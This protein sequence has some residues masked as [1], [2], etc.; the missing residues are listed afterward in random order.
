MPFASLRPLARRPGKSSP[1][2]AVP[3]VEAL[4]GRSLPSATTVTQ[5]TPAGGP[6]DS[7][8]GVALSSVASGKVIETTAGQPFSGVVA[9]FS[10]PGPLAATTDTATINW[11]DGQTSAGTI[12]PQGNGL[13]AVS[14][15]HSYA[16]APASY[17]VVVSLGLTGGGKAFATSTVLVYSFPSGPPINASE[18]QKFSGVVA[19]FTAPNATAAS[20]YTATI[21]W[22]DG[23]TSAGTV[24]ALGNGHF[25]VS[26]SN[27]YAD[28]GTYGVSVRI[29]QG[30]AASWT[31]TTSA[32]VADA[33]FWAT[34]TFQHVGQGQ[35]VT[36]GLGTLTDLNPLATPDDFTVTIDWGDG[37]KTPGTL[38]PTGKGA[39]N[40]AG[41]H[42]YNSA[43]ARTLTVTVTGEGGRVATANPLITVDAPRAPALSATGQPIATKEGQGFNG[44]VATF[45]DPS[46]AAAG[47]YAAAVSWGNGQTSAGTVAALGGG[48][49][50]VSGSNT[51]R[52]AG[53]YAVGV[54]VSRPGGVTAAAA[55]TAVVADEPFWASRTFQR[56]GQGQPVTGVLGTLVDLNPLA[57]AGDFTVTID[58]ADGTK[59]PGLLLPKGNGTFDITGSHDYTSAGARTLDV[60]VTD[61]GGRT[62]TTNPLISVNAW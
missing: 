31:V 49:F 55:T 3:A 6:T 54:Q 33:L 60:T 40:I 47:A 50:A 7:G 12:A 51:Y 30:G 56:V 52:H 8:H 44:V 48:R 37:G 36:G 46:P 45:S 61:E 20:D 13:F 23:Q 32:R 62:I 15:T 11:G 16:N 43:G 2:R 59:S 26:G 57:T 17:P 39:F 18:G 53:T 22:G 42:A 10:D 19:S 41:T 5:L 58:W 28:A 1:R 21:S 38:Q 14:G 29:D 35:P 27:T 25:A 24:T 4:E 9:T 34:R